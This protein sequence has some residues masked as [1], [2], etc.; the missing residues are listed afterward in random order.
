MPSA[1]SAAPGQAAVTNAPVAPGI[2]AAPAGTP[3]KKV[4]KREELFMVRG[5]VM[6]LKPEGLMIRSYISGFNPNAYP[7]KKPNTPESRKLAEQAAREERTAGYGDLQELDN[8][9]WR[10]TSWIPDKFA[11]GTVYLKDY[12]F[13]EQVRPGSK[14]KVVAAP[15][16]TSR[17][18]YTVR[19]A[20]DEAK[21]SWIYR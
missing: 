6:G 13:V 11:R 7:D 16:A 19:F 8:G 9:R 15:I 20:V 10:R 17:M 18:A 4:F 5:E 3:E 1:D 2:S 12:P 21:G 14:I